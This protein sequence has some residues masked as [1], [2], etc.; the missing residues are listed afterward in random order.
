MSRRVRSPFWLL[1]PLFELLGGC[2]GRTH[3]PVVVAMKPQAVHER[4]VLR[5][6]RTPTELRLETT[7][8]L[9]S[10]T[11]PRAD[12]FRLRF[13]RS[14][15]SQA[16]P[17]FA[18]EPD[19]T[20]GE[21]LKV[22]ESETLLVVRGARALLRIDKRPLRLRLLDDS[23]GVIAD[24][25]ARAELDDRGARLEL[26]LQA[27]ERV[28]GLGDKV[29]G[30]DRRG[31]TFELWNTDAFGW[32]V[33]QDPLYKAIPFWLVARPGQSYGVFVDYPG[34]AKVDVGSAV[35]DRLTFDAPAAEQLDVYVLPGPEPKRVLDAYTWLTGRMPLPPLWALGHH[36]SRYGYLSEE[37]VRG[38]VT[39]MQKEKIP[40]D[41]IWLDIDFQQDKAPFLVNERA[42]PSFAKM[43]AD[44]RASGVSTV[45]ISDPHIKSYQGKPPVGYAP[46]DSGA[47][48]DHFVRSGTAFFEGPVWPGASVF[49]EFTLARTRA[50]WGELYRGFVAQGVAGFWNDMNEPALLGKAKTFPDDVQHRL[51]GGGTAPHTLIHNVYGLLNVR[52]TYEGVRNLRPDVR[53]FVLT[54]AAYAGAQRYAASWTGDNVADRAHLAVTIPQLS[55]LGVSGYAFNG[56]DV[57]GFA[58]CPDAELFAEWMEL[59]AL[60]PFF[61]NHSHDK[62]CR[63]EPWLFGAAV[64]TRARRAVEQRYELLP[65]LYTAFEESA[66]N[67][68]PVMRPL[69]LEYPND[70]AAYETATVY[71]LGRDLLVAPK[72]LAGATRYRVTL[73]DDD[74]YDVETSERLSGGVHELSPRSRS[75]SGGSVRLFA[76]AGAIVPTQ[77][78]VQSARQ[79]P[80]GALALAV[81]PGPHCSGSLYLDD[82]ESFA[83]QQGQLRRVE[84]GCERTASSFVVEAR[85][86]GPHPTW[87]RE[88]SLTLH[89]IERAPLAVSDAAGNSLPHRFDAA[90]RRVV[91][92]VPGAAA[93]F[94]V[95]ASW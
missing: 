15:A 92:T 43:V 6:L 69:W 61:R 12:A 42:F 27:G 44:F 24:D 49:P 30:F 3:A 80:T 63:R 16:L 7:H 47:N 75:Q 45:V 46:Y 17:S 5:S 95:V 29:K 77:P 59:G 22:E 68:V 84:Y 76:R 78:V 10:V 26:G 73:P 57:G 85:S 38:V 31:Q 72:L 74:W 67:G 55:N 82:G 39:R 83:Y 64:T 89:D 79:A 41:G 56:A 50:W 9:L 11:A 8:G 88:T 48:G 4:A 20:R 35:A 19:Q 2:L 23:G 94:R 58:G 14:I 71:L 90:K 1:L 86:T 70:P 40:L 32:K 91:V 65:Y 51:E 25:L 87:W 33:D 53:P 93:D 13:A 18:V 28:F 62:A 81:W 37:D 52:A 54:R 21:P 60:Q 66:R 36:Q 34:R